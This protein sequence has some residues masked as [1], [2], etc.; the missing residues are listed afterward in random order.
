MM[1]IQQRTRVERLPKSDYILFCFSCRLLLLLFFLIFLIRVKDIEGCL[2]GK[3]L[4][5]IKRQANKTVNYIYIYIYKLASAKSRNNDKL[6]LS[7]CLVCRRH[8][9]FQCFI[10]YVVS[11]QLFSVYDGG[12]CEVVNQLKNLNKN[13]DRMQSLTIAN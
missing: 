13:A 6:E 5:K 4:S 11:F 8:V 7:P 3:N 1:M 10:F 9:C 2:N 12:R